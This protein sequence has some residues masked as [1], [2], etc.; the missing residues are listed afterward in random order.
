MPNTDVS[1]TPDT[2]RLGTGFNLVHYI[3]QQIPQ[4][5]SVDVCTLDEI[6]KLFGLQGCL[7]YREV[8]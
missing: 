4:M 7:P 5:Y 8:D 6:H 2:I 3:N 1:F